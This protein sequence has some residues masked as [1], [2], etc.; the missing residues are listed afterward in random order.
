MPFDAGALPLLII[1]DAA[2]H[3]ADSDDDVYC[4]LLMMC[5]AAD[6][7]ALRFRH[8]DADFASMRADVDSRLLM[9]RFRRLPLLSLS[10]MPRCH[11][12]ADAA[13]L[14]PFSL[15]MMLYAR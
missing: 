7:D 8:A 9:L 6:A 3:A 13:M 12:A 2:A 5:A 4:Q 11:Y 15:M 1:D 10:L 14:S